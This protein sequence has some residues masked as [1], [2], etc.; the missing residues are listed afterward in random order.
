MDRFLRFVLRHRRLLAATAAGLAVY[1]ALSAVTAEPEG[2]TVVIASRD[3]DSGTRLRSSDVR[4]TS[5][6]LGFVPVG[7]FADTVGTEVDWLVEA[8]RT[9]DPAGILPAPDDRYFASFLDYGP[10]DALSSRRRLVRRH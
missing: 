9:G 10:E 3:L 7:T 4:A 8:Q 6:P 5:M 1:F 2:R